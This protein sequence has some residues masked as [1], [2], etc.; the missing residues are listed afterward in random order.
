MQHHA[1]VNDP[2]N[3]PDYVVS[4]GGPLFLIAPRFF[5]HE[6]FFFQRRLWR[7][8]ELLE[9]A[10]SRG[11][12]ALIIA[13]A[14]SQ[15]ELGYIFNFWFTPLGV[16]GLMLGL[17]FDYFPHHPHQERDRWLNAR[18]YPSAILNILILGQNYHL[19]HHLWPSVPWYKFQ[20]AYYA[21]KELLDTKGCTQ[22]LGITEAK[23]LRKFAY[24]FF[25][26]IHRRHAPE[27]MPIISESERTE[28]TPA[29]PK[30]APVA[31]KH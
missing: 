15:G 27:P 31:L 4:T 25:I 13:F 3:D 1:N 2:D 16:V 20:G 7:K 10:I 14:A 18:V 8:Y 11:L 24:D 5:Y 29:E 21:T 22:T 30:P 9:W 26:G 17:F 23:V 19:V 12:L 28:L 6:I